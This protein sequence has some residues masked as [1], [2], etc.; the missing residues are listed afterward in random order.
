MPS[1][2]AAP[3]AITIVIVC[4]QYFGSRSQGPAACSNQFCYSAGVQS[5]VP[6][7]VF[8]GQVLHQLPVGPLFPGFHFRHRYHCADPV[9]K[10]ATAQIGQDLFEAVWIKVQKDSAFCIVLQTLLPASAEHSSKI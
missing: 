4:P 8:Q 1:V 10:G 5:R 7:V 6:Y 9:V 3:P 2:A